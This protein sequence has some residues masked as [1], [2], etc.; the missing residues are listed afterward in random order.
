MKEGSKYQ[1]LLEFLRGSNQSEVILTFAEIEALMN[2]PL[3]DSAK[4]KRAWWSNR[5]KGA[6]Q[7]LAW[8]EAGYRVEDVDLD[9]QRVTFRKPTTGYQVQRVGDTVLWNSE[10]IK[11]LRLHM[12]LTQAEFA[13]RLGVRQATVSQWENKAY[14]PTLA[15][16]K[17]LTLI[18]E[19]AEFRVIEEG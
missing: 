9:G 8:M 13:E 1:P 17:Y 19:Q 6:L 12:G 14:E 18:A 16:S 10:L 3:P 7:A 5:S 15:T 4:S 11:A 2:N